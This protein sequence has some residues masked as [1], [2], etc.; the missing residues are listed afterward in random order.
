MITFPQNISEIARSLPLSPCSLVDLIKV[1]FV[2]GTIPSKEQLRSILTVRRETIRRAL[3]WLHANNVLYRDVAI[4]HLLINTL[5]DDDVP[6]LLWQTIS[7]V[8][9]SE[10]NNVERSGYADNELIPDEARFDGPIAL[11]VSGLTDAHALVT[12]SGD[13]AQHLMKKMNPIDPTVRE[14][15]K[16]YLVSRGQRPV[17]GYFNTAFLPGILIGGKSSIPLCVCG[18]TLSN[19]VS[20]RPRRCGEL[21]QT[22]N[23]FVYKTSTILSHLL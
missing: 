2:G 10:S 11:A 15:E 18:R 7:I 12:S 17:N 9:E 22:K 4:D 23:R 19:I 21:R 8:E 1:I 13:I 6:D 5:P 14:D 16:I 3:I 20:I